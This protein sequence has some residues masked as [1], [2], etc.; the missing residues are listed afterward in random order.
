MPKYDFFRGSYLPSNGTIANGVLHE[1]DLYFQGQTFSCHAY[2]VKKIRRQRMSAADLPRL[3]WPRPSRPCSCFCL[4]IIFASSKTFLKFSR[5]PHL[6]IRT[7]ILIWCNAP[8]RGGIVGIYLNIQVVE[9]YVNTRVSS[10]FIYIPV[11]IYVADTTFCVRF[12]NL[13]KTRKN[14]TSDVSLLLCNVSC[15]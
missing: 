9:L 1:I 8:S 14:R 4:S 6:K 12:V 3:A 11:H 13:S 5:V 10:S 15:C 2:A 7:L